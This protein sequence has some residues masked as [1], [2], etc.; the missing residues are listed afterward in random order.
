MFGGSASEQMAE[1][2]RAAE[3]GTTLR[4]LLC[5]LL[6]YSRSGEFYVEKD[7][8]EEINGEFALRGSQLR[9]TKDR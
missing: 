3:E 4:S 8:L 2:I 9:E 7:G 1:E 5:D 6:S